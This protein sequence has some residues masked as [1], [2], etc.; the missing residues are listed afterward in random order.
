VKHK[1]PTSAKIIL[2][3]SIFIFIVLHIMGYI[4]IKYR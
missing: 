4:W 3:I 1:A 2:G